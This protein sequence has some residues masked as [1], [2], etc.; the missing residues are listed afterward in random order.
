MDQLT[1]TVRRTYWTNI[2]AQCQNRSDDL[3]IK[4]WLSNNGISEK[5][6]YYWLR[7]FRTEAFEQT[8]SQY[9]TLPAC[10][11]ASFAE[12]SAPP[13]QQDALFS[14]GFKADAV[15]KTESLV[16]ALSNTVS[17]SLL[18]CVM[19]GLKHAR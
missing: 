11:H 8:E 17:E 14:I 5:A 15:I 6:Y 3:T 9:T 18:N 16:I 12:I 1:H 10:N 19:E 13:V 7:K 4:Q 2:I